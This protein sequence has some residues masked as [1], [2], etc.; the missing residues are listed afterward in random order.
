MYNF[1][2]VNVVVK[3]EDRVKRENTTHKPFLLSCTLVYLASH[4][5]TLAK[6]SRNENFEVFTDEISTNVS[7]SDTN[8]VIICY[9]DY[10]AALF[11]KMFC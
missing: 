4:F 1:R 11:I 2:G 6:K 5:S 7:K 3:N 8:V 9:L 10:G